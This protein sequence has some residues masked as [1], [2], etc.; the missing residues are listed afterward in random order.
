MQTYFRILISRN[1]YDGG[2]R[3]FGGGFDWLITNLMVLIISNSAIPAC[4]FIYEN[5]DLVLANI[6]VVQHTGGILRAR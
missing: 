3:K 5:R 1:S 4:R 6:K 2:L